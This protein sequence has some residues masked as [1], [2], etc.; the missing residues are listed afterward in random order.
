MFPRALFLQVESYI[1]IPVVTANLMLGLK[2]VL[3]QLFYYICKLIG[4]QSIEKIC[5]Y[6]IKLPA[7]LE[8]SVQNVITYVSFLLLYCI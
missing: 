5:L 6:L 2:Y 8:L 1:C 7:I 3:L 4:L